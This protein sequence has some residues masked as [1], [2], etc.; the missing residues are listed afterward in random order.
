M[1]GTAEVLPQIRLALVSPPALAEE[2]LQ[3]CPG[4]IYKDSIKRDIWDSYFKFCFERNPFDKAISRYYWSTDKMAERPDI[5][6]YLESAQQGLLSNWAI[7]SDNDNVAVDFVGK[8]ENIERDLATIREKI[9]L[10]GEL[11]LVNAK[12][13]YRKDHRHYSDVLD[14]RARARNE[15]AC[16]K[17]IAEFSYGWISVNLRESVQ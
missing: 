5:A 6:D 1:Y 13:G 2:I 7:Y 11:T 15:R 10:A 12:G 3:S 8:Y 9:G 4:E 16:A 17:E 14:P